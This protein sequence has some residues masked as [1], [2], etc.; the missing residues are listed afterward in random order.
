MEKINN[1]QRELKLASKFL[2]E[3]QIVAIPTDTYYGLACDPFSF[4][5]LN[6]LFELKFSIRCNNSR[7]SEILASSL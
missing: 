6:K 2:R 1:Y 7:A 4:E 3:G 5:A